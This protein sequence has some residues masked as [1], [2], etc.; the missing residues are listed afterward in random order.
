[1]VNDGPEDGII[2]C[3]NCYLKKFGPTSKLSYDE[4]KKNI[5][6]TKMED[7][8]LKNCPRCQSVVYPNEQVVT[9]GRSYHRACARCIQCNH[10]LN[11]MTL[12]DAPDEVQWPKS[13]KSFSK[14]QISTIFD[15]E[16]GF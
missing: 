7:S 8:S 9:N 12:F 1:M 16:F 2:F 14:I 11:Q 4:F 5:D 6:A 13:K 10:Q 3:N 15:F